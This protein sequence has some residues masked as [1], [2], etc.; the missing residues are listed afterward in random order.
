MSLDSDLAALWRGRVGLGI[1]VVWAAFWLWFGLACGAE[2]GPLAALV[3][4]APFLT[5]ALAAWLAWRWPKGGPWAL[6]VIGVAVAVVY[7]LTMGRGRPDWTLFIWLTMA[8]PPILAG[9]L[10]LTGQP[11]RPAD[12][13]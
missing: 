8:W 2:D 11:E 5:F 10:I 3:H 12:S 9:I 6:V 1:A 7:P 13:F 4:A